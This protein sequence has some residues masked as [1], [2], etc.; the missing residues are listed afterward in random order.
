M[1]LPRTRMLSSGRHMT[2]PRFTAARTVGSLSSDASSMAMM[3]SSVFSRPNAR[4]IAFPRRIAASCR[5]D[6]RRSF[7]CRI[8]SSSFA[9]RTFIYCLQLRT[10]SPQIVCE[11]FRQ[12]SESPPIRRDRSLKQRHRL[13]ADKLMVRAATSREPL[14]TLPC[15]RQLPLH[16]DVNQELHRASINDHHQSIHRS[17]SE[18]SAPAARHHAA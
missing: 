14:P 9:V 16:V 2:I 4:R 13:Q 18:H 11:R 3:S 6:G 12:F 1:V 8:S 5:G 17:G 10:V 15:C 7:G